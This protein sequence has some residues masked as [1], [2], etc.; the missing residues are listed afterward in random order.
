MFSP[1]Q[2]TS[3]SDTVHPCVCSLTGSLCLAG[4]PPPRPTVLATTPQ[5]NVVFGSS[6]LKAEGGV[7]GREGGASGQEGVASGRGLGIE[8]VLLGLAA[9]AGTCGA[10]GRW[11]GQFASSNTEPGG[12]ASSTFPVGSRF[13]DR[14]VSPIRAPSSP[15]H[16]HAHGPRPWDKPGSPTCGPGSPIPAQTY[17]ARIGDSPIRAAGSPTPTHATWTSRRDGMHGLEHGPGSRKKHLRAAFATAVS[18][19]GNLHPQM[20]PLPYA[21]TGKQHAHCVCAQE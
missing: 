5:G 2:R 10:A 17:T 1:H 18:G 16:T 20:G 14:P 4:L 7:S 9:V 3:S 6:R 21:G 15:L 12:E 19:G 11:G 8:G 13:G